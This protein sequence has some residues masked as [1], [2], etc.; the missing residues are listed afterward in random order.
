LVPDLI[1]PTEE[2]KE[3]AFKIVEDL[4]KVIVLLE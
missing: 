3:K 1:E 2:M 4:E